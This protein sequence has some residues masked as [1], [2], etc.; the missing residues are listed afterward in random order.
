[1]EAKTSTQTVRFLIDVCQ[2]HSRFYRYA[3]HFENFLKT[4]KYWSDH[5]KCDEPAEN[6][7]QSPAKI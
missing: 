3:S 1:M 5:L 7:S 6:F 4:L 2:L